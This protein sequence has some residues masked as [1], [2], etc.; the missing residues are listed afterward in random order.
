L[1]DETLDRASRRLS[2]GVAP[3]ASIESYL[4]GIARNVARE[5]WK[6]P[7]A[8]VVDW[9]Q[10]ASEPPGEEGDPRTGCLEACLG[11]LTPKSRDWVERFYAHQGAEKI[12]VRQALAAELSIDTNALRVR[13]HRIRAKLATCV[14]ECLR[15]NETAGKTTYERE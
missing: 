12:R 6:R 4:L 10:L 3:Q 14:T 1:A 15:G 5:E 13:L 9:A 7:R 8:A 2:D 11:E